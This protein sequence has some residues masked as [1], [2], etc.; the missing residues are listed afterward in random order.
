MHRAEQTCKS[1]EQT[2][3]GLSFVLL[4]ACAHGLEMLSIF[5]EQAAKHGMLPQHV[6]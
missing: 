6:G 2:P 4:H 3:I 1:T 5:T